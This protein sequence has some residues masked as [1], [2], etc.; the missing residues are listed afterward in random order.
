[1]SSGKYLFMFNKS[2]YNDELESIMNI[3]QSNPLVIKLYE[4][5]EKNNTKTQIK[6]PTMTI[7]VDESILTTLSVKAIFCYVSCDKL[8]PLCLNI[9]PQYLTT[10]I[11]IPS[12]L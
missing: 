6:I 1:M 8:R 4:R 7:A 9:S 11:M 10:L 3:Q 5:R 2:K 12:I